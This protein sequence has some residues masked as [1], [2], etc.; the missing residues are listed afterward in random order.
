MIF[1]RHGK[2]FGD[3]NS[4]VFTR[5]DSTTNFIYKLTIVKSYAGNNASGS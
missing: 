3:K 4:E 5:A 2:E 1:N